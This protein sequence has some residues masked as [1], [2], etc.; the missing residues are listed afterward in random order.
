MQPVP[1]TSV[2][3]RRDPSFLRT[4][5]RVNV[6]LTT[7]A[8]VRQLVLDDLPLQSRETLEIEQVW[9]QAGRTA[10]CLLPA[11][12]PDFGMV[13]AQEDRRH[14]E[15]PKG[16]WPREL[17]V[18]EH[19][20]VVGLLGDRGG[21]DDPWHQARDGVDDDA[22]G[23]LAAGQHVVTDRDLLGAQDL[24]RAVVDPLVASADDRDP[25]ARRELLGNRLLE[26]PATRRHDE[27]PRSAELRSQRR[28]DR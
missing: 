4:T 11:P 19:S 25:L 16:G 12:A 2:M 5:R 14:R 22:R 18:F 10:E 6:A 21:I 7:P 13:S 24:D 9:S 15:T 1:G 20:L 23:Q 17:R 26:E 28:F 8:V 27:D 3:P